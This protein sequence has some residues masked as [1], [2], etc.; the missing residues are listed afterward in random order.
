MSEIRVN[1]L[2]N[3]AG[4]GP[5]TLTKQSA[6]KAWVNTSPTGINDSFN[7]SSFTDDGTG[8]FTIDITNNLSDANYGMSSTGL[9][10]TSTEVTINNLAAGSFQL[11]VAT[12]GGTLTDRGAGAAAFGD[13][14]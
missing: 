9:S 11:L 10:S 2:S 5:A 14:A 8:S 3:E 1:T 12:S 13:L 4:T 7:T 6:A